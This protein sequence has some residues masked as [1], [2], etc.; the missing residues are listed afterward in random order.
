MGVRVRK[1]RLRIPGEATYF[2]VAAVF[3]GRCD[4]TKGRG[5]LRLSRRQDRRGIAL[6]TG[7]LEDLGRVVDHRVDA[8]E[9]L[10]QAQLA[11]MIPPS[12]SEIS[13]LERSS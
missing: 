12:L 9:L 4:V 3:S 8:G 5:R 10:Q 13:E 2:A 11:V 1:A 7:A 6:E